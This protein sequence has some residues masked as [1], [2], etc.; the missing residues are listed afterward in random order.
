M[1]GFLNGIGEVATGA[2]ACLDR[3]SSFRTGDDNWSRRAVDRRMLAAS[4]GPTAN[5]TYVK[6]LE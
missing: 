3:Q 1:D 5:L 6:F 4:A 2:K